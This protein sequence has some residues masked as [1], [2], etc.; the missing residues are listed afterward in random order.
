MTTSLK[1]RLG[2]RRAWRS[3]RLAALLTVLGLVLVGAV[4]PASGLQSAVRARTRDREF[5]FGTWTL[6][7]ILAKFA[8][9]GLSLNR[10][11]DPQTQSQV[12][13]ETLEQVRRVKELE[14]QV[15]LIYADPAVT[16]PD[17]ASA[18]RRESL[19]VEAARLDGLRPLAEAILQAQLLEIL[20]AARLEVLGQVVPPS[21]FQSSTMP[22]SLV[23]SP[24][25]VIAQALEVSLSPGL[26][27]EAMDRLEEEI[28]TGLNHAALVVPVGGVG[29]YPT[30]VMETADIVWLTEVIAHE[31]THNFLTLRPLGINYYTDDALRTINET[32]ASLAGKELGRMILEKYYPEFVPQE[33]E[34][35]PTGSVLLRPEP[36]PEA[37]DFR[38]E[39]RVT[40]VEVD[41]LLAE[42]AIEEAEA[43]MAARRAFFWENGHLIRKLNQAYFAFYG[44]YNDVP[45]GGAA[46]EDPV[47]PAVVAFRAKFISL[48]DFLKA[49]S[50]V[51]SYDAL[52]ELLDG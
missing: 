52:L 11:L 40:R 25:E 20:Q 5:D 3:L 19:A 35:S 49:I 42:G 31:W 51:T 38:A 46:G 48:G 44:A 10:F 15:L 4:V 8:G 18:P 39:M 30:M 45:G 13:L 36:D 37:F 47:G 23:I 9:W 2:L 28:F 34:P 33:V 27:T 1:I 14:A 32:T 17:A 16:D 26:T 7:A 43:Y 24:R 22:Y 21:L 29:T 41:R 12:V 6:D 50:W